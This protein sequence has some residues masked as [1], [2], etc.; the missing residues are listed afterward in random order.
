MFVGYLN[1][2]A[3]ATRIFIVVFEK[4]R[5]SQFKFVLRVQGHLKGNRCDKQRVKIKIITATVFK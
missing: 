5:S 1:K 4:I 3:A 2:L